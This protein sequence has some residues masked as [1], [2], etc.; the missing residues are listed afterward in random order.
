LEIIE[1]Q[2]PEEEEAVEED[3]YIQDSD[4]ING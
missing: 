2:N 3:E 1:S 4:D